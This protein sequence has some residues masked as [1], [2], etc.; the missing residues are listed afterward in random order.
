MLIRYCLMIAGLMMSLICSGCGP[1]IGVM[2]AP[3]HRPPMIDAEYELP[4]GEVL[5]LVD[6]RYVSDRHPR[7]RKILTHALADELKEHT[8]VKQILP[9]ASLA[10]FRA[11]R[12]DFYSLRPEVVGRELGAKTV[13]EVI[14]CRLRL[15]GGAGGPLFHGEIEVRS[16][17]VN[18]KNGRQLW[19]DEHRGRTVRTTIPV[20]ESRS[21]DHPEQLAEQLS[22][23]LALRLAQ[24]FYDHRAER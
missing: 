7:I 22:E 1:I 14:I 2:I 23:Q 20:H 17:V 19:P 12:T 6:D 11:G 18:V 3:F 10:S 24:L 16:K 21:K 4:D 13:I 8:D 15:R 9:Y 5:I